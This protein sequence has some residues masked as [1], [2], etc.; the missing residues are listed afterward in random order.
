MQELQLLNDKLD[1]LLKSYAELQAENKRLKADASKQERALVKLNERIA[2]YEADLNAKH[3]VEATISSGDKNK[4]RKQLD[5]VISE[6]DKILTA[7]ND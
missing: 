3:V 5:T 7:L 6:I 1:Q 2:G 4:M